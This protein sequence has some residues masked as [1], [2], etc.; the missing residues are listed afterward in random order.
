M[1][2][3]V[4]F[5]QAGGEMG[6][7]M[8]ALDWSKTALGP[9]QSWPTSLKTI[10]RI[11]LDSRY[12]MWFA[13]GSDLIFFCND[14]Y[15]PTLG[16]KKEWAIGSS[17]RKVWEEIWPDI[18][19]RID[20]V[21]Q[22]GV[23]TWDEG[24]QLF[25]ERSGTREETYHTFSYSP[26]P[27][28]A[29]QIGGMLCVVTEETERIIGERR[30]ILLRDL[31]ARLA[32]ATTEPEVFTALEETLAESSDV[33]FSV[34]FIAAA[35]GHAMSPC[36]MTGVDHSSATDAR[37]WPL[38]EVMAKGAAVRVSSIAALGVQLPPDLF[39]RPASQALLL[40]ISQAGRPT[41]AGVFI[42]GLSPDRPFDSAYEGFLTLLAGQIS[43]ALTSARS[44]DAERTRAEELAKLDKAKTI[45]FSN[46]SHE[47]R[48]PLTLMIGPTQAAL[49]S[50]EQ[51]LGG[52][53][54][55]LVFRNQNRLLK[56]VNSLLDF[57]RLEAG[58]FTSMF[59][60]VNLAS[61]TAELASGFSSATERGGLSLQVSCPPLQEPVYI[62]PVS[63]E[64]IVLNLLSNA[65]KFTHHGGIE[66]SVASEDTYAL[67]QVKDT[68]I[69]IAATDLPK[70]FDRFH[71]V[72]GA[73]GR[74]HEG[75]GI[76]LALV[77]E[78]VHLHGG[79]INVAS[80]LG[81]G[82]TI[83]VR[84][85]LGKE[86]IAADRILSSAPL[87]AAADRAYVDEAMS[88]MTAD[89]DTPMRSL[90]SAS[91]FGPVADD[92]ATRQKILLA[93]DNAD[94]RHYIGRLLSPQWNVK[95]VGDGEAALRAARTEHPDLIVTDVMMPML[96]GF[97]LLRALRDDPATA[98]IPVL[99]LSA[100]A[101]LEARIEGFEAGADDYL[102]KPFS[103]RELVAR[104]SSM[105]AL[106]RARREALQR[107]H[108]LR[109]ETDN[110]LESM[111]EGFM[112]LDKAWRMVYLNTAAERILEVPRGEL[113]G[114]VLWETFEKTW[115]SEV[116][117]A[118]Q[119]AMTEKTPSRFEYYYEPWNRW[120]EVQVYPAKQG[121]SVYFREISE[122]KKA[123]LALQQADRR[124]DE[125]LA[126][127]AHELRNPLAPLQTAAAILSSPS[128][129]PKHIQ[130]TQKILDR[131]V[132]HMARLLDDLLDVSRVTRG[133]LELKRE[134][135]PL[136]QVIEIALEAVKPLIDARRHQ[137]LVQQARDVQVHVDPVR[138]A[139]V[140]AN[141]LNNAAK[142]TDPCGKIAL[143][144]DTDG[145]ELIFEI[146]D[147]GIGLLPENQRSIFEMFSQLETALNRSQ[148]GLGIG[149]A[150]V[151]GVVDLHGG[152]V[153]VYSEGPGRGSSFI[154]RLPGAVQPSPTTSIPAA[155][156][157]DPLPRRQR[158]LVAD[159]NVDAA[160]TLAELLRLEGYEVDV[161]EDG[162]QAIAQVHL[163]MPDV[164]LLDIGM[165]GL[166]GYE[167]A[168]QLR[169]SHGNSITLIALTG[170]GQEG[171]RRAARDAGFD[172][173]LV[174]PADPDE[175][176]R[177]I[178]AVQPAS[179]TG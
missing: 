7:R 137:L 143:K 96:D 169:Q 83:S 6:A 78:L 51:A 91:L 178:G 107:E 26:I 141:L 14:A 163:N 3:L 43:A 18:G 93:D 88:W 19:P 46:V 98:S 102:A 95:V 133:R 104:V 54:L 94:M 87:Q 100:R 118:C 119:A 61:F 110:V 27:D 38:D 85:P 146:T 138:I 32:V 140:L 67:L 59:Q 77:R 126:T 10:V 2:R 158:V 150:L 72:E 79:S 157:L 31:A 75:T 148:G 177:L 120:F 114:K 13:W 40:P 156:K 65:L 127:L 49:E 132:K 125:F 90:G 176:L 86:H 147:N 5:L 151:K 20:T 97:G 41:P 179:V 66:V 62:D 170:W 153:Q 121:I 4:D 81:H 149:L 64:K 35:G 145:D 57:A 29:G 174:K 84:I 36:A 89:V 23:A 12:A 135:A 131:Q 25:L 55:N 17:A 9:P 164:A 134:Y 30:L 76:G 74:S 56:L 52:D 168:Q 115:E 122:T 11:A 70:L 112:T 167:V 128:L 73:H 108:A 33:V 99:L 63:W 123:I 106:T 103:G 166:S 15:S 8:R 172:H 22:T 39:Q 21:M 50:R 113:I 58:R 80:V 28:D 69:G 152:T 116:G 44:Y 68:G 109:A 92:P 42:A 171:D 144:V 159:D 130:S 45:F 136:S 105:L 162:R 53:D 139:Q 101:G 160:Q 37:S 16:I 154:I 173:H 165:P 117:Y 24:L 111:N 34:V 175:I 60:P 48:T 82:T 161:A 142:Y 129:Q 1:N 47:L 71:R 155:Q 124:K